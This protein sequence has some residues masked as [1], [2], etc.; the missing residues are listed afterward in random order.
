MRFKIDENLPVDAALYLRQEGFD[1][2]T[3]HDEGLRGTDDGHL[4][5]A[6]NRENRVLIT[7]D[8]DFADI[9]AYPP[10]KYAGLIVLRLRRQDVN[11]VLEVLTRLVPILRSESPRQKLW[12]VDEHRIRIKE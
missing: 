2:V 7:L 1:A 5:K 3:L 11:S 12:I 9:L 6:C 4:I 10:A 8:L